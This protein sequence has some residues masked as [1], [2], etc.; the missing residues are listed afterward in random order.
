MFC[1][2]DQIP[3]ILDSRQEPTVH[4]TAPGSASALTNFASVSREALGREERFDWL[5]S[6]SN[7]DGRVEDALKRGLRASVGVWYMIENMEYV[8]ENVWYKVLNM[9]FRISGIW[10]NTWHVESD[11]HIAFLVQNEVPQADEVGEPIDHVVHVLLAG[12]L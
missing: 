8:I 6:G 1:T 9:W 12:E 10:Q 2:T 11:C 3:C 4:D 7:L 5:G